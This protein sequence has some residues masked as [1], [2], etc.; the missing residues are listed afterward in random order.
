[1]FST[2]FTG[3]DQDAGFFDGGY[4][5]VPGVKQFDPAEVVIRAWRGAAT[6]EQAL[7]NRFA[8]V[9][10]SSVFTNR[11]GQSAPL[12]GGVNPAP[13]LNAPSFTIYPFPDA[14]RLV[15]FVGPRPLCIDVSANGET[16]AFTWTDLGTNYV[17]TLEGIS[18]LSNTNWTRVAGGPWPS[19]TNQWTVPLP[20]V[21]NRF[22]R[23]KAEL[24][25]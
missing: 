2:F 17:Y 7:T 13:L 15:P 12:P 1:M 25:P 11:T 24:Q 22:Y 8:F 14:C 21:S 6:W 5:V 4:G 19:N 3:R 20:T 18:S 9:G 10:E 16:L 23:V